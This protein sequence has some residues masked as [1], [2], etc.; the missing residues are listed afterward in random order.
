MGDDIRAGI[1]LSG[2][3]YTAE[4][5]Y[6]V[7][8][9]DADSQRNSREQFE[10]KLKREKGDDSP[11]H[12]KLPPAWEKETGGIP[13]EIKDGLILSDSAKKILVADP[14]VVPAVLPRENETLPVKASEDPKPAEEPP[15][16]PVRHID[17]KA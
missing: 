8:S 2:K 6:H 1:P 16:P 9:V 17:L 7:K 15:P 5:I 4:P 11:D 14:S 12:Q 3:D 10:D 13:E